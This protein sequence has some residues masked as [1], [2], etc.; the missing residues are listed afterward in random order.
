M[1][2]PSRL[3]DAS[4]PWPPSAFR[5]AAEAATRRAPIEPWGWIEI[6]V[7]AQ[8][9]WGALLF[10]P[11]MQAL[12]LAVRVLPYATSLGALAFFLR[13]AGR[14]RLPP[15]APWLFGVFALMGMNLLHEGS[16]L[17]AGIG[18]GAL[19][20]AIAAPALWAGSVV[21]SRARFE[22]VLWLVFAASLLSAGLGVLQTYYPD[23]FLPPE[24]SSL[25]REMNP[26]IVA[27]LT[28]AGADGQAIIRPPGLSDLPGGAAAAGMMTVVLGVALASHPTTSFLWRLLTL[29]GAAV[30]MTAL[31]LTQVRSL[32]V[33]AVASMLLMAAVRLRQGKVALGGWIV[34]GGVALVAASFVWATAVGGDAVYDRFASLFGDGVINTYQESRGAFLKYTV[35]EMLETYPFGAG[36]GRWGMMQVYLGD[37]THWQAPPIYVELQI[38]GWL[39]DGGVPMWFLYGGALLAAIRYAYLVALHGADDTLR[40]MATVVLTFLVG[41]V[42]M[43]FSGPVF[44]TQLGIVFWTLAALFG[45]VDATRRHDTQGRGRPLS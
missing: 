44:N 40:S 11:G 45:V 26:D 39:L 1:S 17:M 4:R 12:R 41:I 20:V 5:P 42:G 19:Q 9:L 37:P 34:A 32:S 3:P 30:G 23:Q 15:S 35:V 14:D 18:Q 33:L 28:Y 13:R 36:L 31:Y 27:S 21:H 8:L 7:A 2:S 25:A 29:G 16:H 22:R 24:F 43:C 38:T 10:I 6:F